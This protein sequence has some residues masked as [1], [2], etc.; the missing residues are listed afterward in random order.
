MNKISSLNMTK[1]ETK[2]TT[3]ISTGMIGPLVVGLYA[4]LTAVSFGLVL[5]DIVYA[6]L[7]PDAATALSEA[8][9]FQL[10][11]NFVTVLA[12]LGAIGLAWRSRVSRNFIIS[13]VTLI[14][15]GFFAY[16]L[17]SP[18]LRDGSSLGRGIRILLSGSVSVLAFMGFYRF[19]SSE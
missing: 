11:V 19:H 14:F 9:D 4:W 13:S 7:V 15:L 8:A 5:L 10:R 17:L 16:M 2:N 1:S 3:N 6:G 12:A 18:F